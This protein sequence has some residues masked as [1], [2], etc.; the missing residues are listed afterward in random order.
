M[1]KE[2]GIQLKRHETFSIRE[3][4]LEKAINLINDEKNIFSKNDATSILGIGS[5]MVKS[6]RYW[7]EA[8][9]IAEFPMG[10]LPYLTDFGKYLKEH[11]NY[12]EKIDSWWLIHTHLVTNYDD[13]PV[14]NKLFNLKYSKF[15]KEYLFDIVKDS[16]INDG[17]IITSDSSLKSDID[18]AIKSYFNDDR[19]NPEDNM[20]C[21]LASLKLLSLGS[22][23]IYHRTQPEFSGLSYKVVF[24]GLIIC[25]KNNDYDIKNEFNIEDIFLLV[26]NPLNIYNISKSSFYLYLDEMKKNGLIYMTKTAGL[27]TAKILED[28]SFGMFE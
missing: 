5:N 17:E 28:F 18:I 22:N 3:G 9:R 27:N 13:A 15:D 20:N 8:T 12:L 25:L 21:P 6:L 14:L 4:W 16:F 19:S 1:G 11:D 24:L 26:D 10:K 2:K 7:L 23:K